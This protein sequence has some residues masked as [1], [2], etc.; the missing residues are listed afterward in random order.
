MKKNRKGLLV[1]V[2][3]LLVGLTGGYVASTYAKYTSEVTGT[4]SVTVAKWD[5]ANENSSVD[6]ELDLTTAVNATSLVDGKIAPGTEGDFILKLSNKNSEVGVEFTVD[7]TTATGIPQNLVFNYNGTEFVP[8]NGKL[9]GKIAIGETIDIPISW[10]WPYY[11]SDANDVK[12]T[13]DG[14]AAGTMNLGIKITGVQ[15]DPTESVT[16]GVSVN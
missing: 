15:T 1:I 4:G 5:F 2:L 13:E 3:L 12:D 9:V 6:L 11:T 14:I 10:E 7:F 16:T 8:G